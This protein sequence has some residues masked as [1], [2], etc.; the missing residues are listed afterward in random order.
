MCMCIFITTVFI[1][2]FNSQQP[3]CS[4]FSKWVSQV[5]MAYPVMILK[6]N[7]DSLLSYCCVINYHKLSSLK[8]LRS[9]TWLSWVLC[10]GS[11]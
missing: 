3:K 6:I 5:E 11:Y 1:I 10:S 2:V 9:P 8:H 7:M 4:T